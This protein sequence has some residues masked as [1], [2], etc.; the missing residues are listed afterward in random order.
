MLCPIC[1]CTCRSAILWRVWYFPKGALPGPPVYRASQTTL[2]SH[3]CIVCLGWLKCLIS[4]HQ[5][6]VEL[7]WLLSFLI[8]GSVLPDLGF[9]PE[10]MNCLRNG[11]N[12]NKKALQ[13][14]ALDGGHKL[15]SIWP[16]NHHGPKAQF[17]TECRTCICHRW[18]AASKG[19]APGISEPACPQDVPP[20]PGA[21]RQAIWT[22]EAQR[23]QIPLRRS[24]H[25]HPGRWGQTSF[26][27]CRW[28]SASRSHCSVALETGN[29]SR[30]MGRFP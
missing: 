2:N 28:V 26:G 1:M 27:Q 11:T 18:W 8:L 30:K 6:L 23:P 10:D 5:H 15:W 3:Y 4:A 24:S 7:A 14:P 12:C 29:S 25:H 9:Q 17:G 20:S 16:S 21:V 19:S 22:G 13:Q